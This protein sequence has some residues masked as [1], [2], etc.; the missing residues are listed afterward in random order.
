MKS[1]KEIFKITHDGDG[2]LY[3]YDDNNIMRWLLEVQTYEGDSVAKSIN[4]LIKEIHESDN[5]SRR[6]R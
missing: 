2:K 5:F 1:Q 3:Y 4:Q 6:K